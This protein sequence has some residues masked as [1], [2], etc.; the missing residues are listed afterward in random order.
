MDSMKT[1]APR[2]NQGSPKVAG[3]SNTL[4]FWAVLAITV[5]VRVVAAFQHNRRER[6]RFR[7]RPFIASSLARDDALLCIAMLFPARLGLAV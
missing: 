5:F 3:R 6:F 4:F 1:R 2:N 7:R